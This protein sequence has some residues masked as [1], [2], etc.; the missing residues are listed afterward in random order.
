MALQKT[1]NETLIRQ[2]M[3]RINE[4]DFTTSKNLHTFGTYTRKSS[5][6]CKA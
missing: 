1:K 5:K 3:N 2:I 6:T 4:I